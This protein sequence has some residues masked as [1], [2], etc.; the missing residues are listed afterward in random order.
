MQIMEHVK[1]YP[2]PGVCRGEMRRDLRLMNISRASLFPSLEIFAQSLHSDNL[3]CRAAKVVDVVQSL[4]YAL[5]EEDPDETFKRHGRLEL[6]TES[7][8]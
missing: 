8:L 1:C 3:I 4:K 6:G 5:I 7:D 2:I